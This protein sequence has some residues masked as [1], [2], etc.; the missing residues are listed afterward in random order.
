MVHRGLQ[1]ASYRLLAARPSRL[2]Q[3]IEHCDECAASFL[4]GFFDS[5]AGISGRVLRISNGN[6]AVLSLACELL[7]RLGIET[8]G[9]HLIKSAGGLVL[10]KGKLYR[11]NLDQMYVHVRSMS[12]E[13]FQEKIGF[14][15]K[16]KAVALNAALG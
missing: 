4:R 1:F 16:R 2:R 13:R 3:T 9:I 7:E 8:T 11:Q 12:L 5:E 14:I 10:I 6:K 15:V